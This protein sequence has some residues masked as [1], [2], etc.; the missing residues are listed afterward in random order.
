MGAGATV[1]FDIVNGGMVPDREAVL[2][3]TEPVDKPPEEELESMLP[4]GP[5][6]VVRL[7]VGNGAADTVPVRVAVSVAVKVD[8]SDPLADDGDIPV[9][10]PVP[11]NVDGKGTDSEP[12]SGGGS[13][14]LI[15][16]L[17]RLELVLTV[18][19]KSVLLLPTVELS[20]GSGKGAV[21]ELAVVLG[22]RSVT[23]DE[24]I[25]LVTVEPITTE[26]FADGRGNGAEVGS[27]IMLD[28]WLELANE[29]VAPT[30]DTEELV[31]GPVERG[32]VPVP[33]TVLLELPKGNEAEEGSSDTVPD[34]RS[35]VVVELVALIVESDPETV[36]TVNAVTDTDIVVVMTVA[37][38]GRAEAVVSLVGEGAVT[39]ELIPDI[40]SEEDGRVEV[41]IVSMLVTVSVDSGVLDKIKVREELDSVVV[42]AE[43]LDTVLDARLPVTASVWEN[44]DITLVVI[45]VVIEIPEEIVMIVTVSR[46]RIPCTVVVTPSRSVDVTGPKLLL[47]DDASDK[48]G[49]GWP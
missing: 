13:D 20:E 1:E 12:V 36:T 22:R 43:T 5:G 37:P 8:A 21:S 35:G 4:E 18:N 25:T 34:V 26:E 49:V 15:V 29:P 48:L 11:M 23:S 3:P 19:G 47:E 28:A 2:R 24:D 10:V 14:K 41:L 46:V 27:E 31:T 38:D 17:L 42:P 16:V 45:V 7:D 32:A 30:D 40:T 9:P 33:A 39:V 6:A 44:P